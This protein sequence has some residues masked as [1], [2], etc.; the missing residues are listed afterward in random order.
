[1]AILT[2]TSGEILLKPGV[3]PAIIVEIT[4]RERDG[5]P[6]LLWTFEVKRA[7]GKTTLVR[8]P[9][10]LHFGPKSTARAIVE[11]ILHRK[12][13]DGEQIDTDDLLGLPVQVV[14]SRGTRPD[15]E[16]TNRIEAVL[17]APVEDEDDLPF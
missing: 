13:R 17:P 4:V 8:R 14:I 3:Y 9:T 15:G 6:Y 2:A 10:S 16:E 5:R 1:M 11:A 7:D 12:I